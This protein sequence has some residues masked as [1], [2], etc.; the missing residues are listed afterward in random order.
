MWTERWFLSC[1]AK[2]IGTLYL[3]FAL[4]SGLIGTAYSVLIRLELS[5]P[6]VQFIADNQ[7]Y[8][9]IITSHAILMIFFM[10]MP[11][12]IGGFGN[13]LLPLLVGGPDMANKS[14]NFKSHILSKYYSTNKNIN[15]KHK[16]QILGHYLAG[17]IEGDGY[18]SLTKRNQ[19]EIGITFNSKDR[20]SAEK[21]LSY[22][23]QGSLLKRKGNCV[24]LKF[25]AVKTIKRI[26]LLINGKFRTPKIDK[27]HMLIDWLNKKHSMNLDKLPLD[28]SPLY[29]NSW[30]AGFIDADGHFY[31]RN[32]VN[33]TIICKFSLEQRMIYPKTKE[34][35]ESILGQICLFLNV[36]LFTRAR[37]DKDNS[38]YYVIRVENQ[39]ST[40]ILIDYLDS[41]SLLS[42]KYLDYLN[43]KRAFN[44]IINKTHKTDEGKKIITSLKNNMNDKR[45]F[46]N[47]D[48]FKFI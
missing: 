16:D 38:S 5:G 6:G 21:L 14:L 28:N 44:E 15:N 35:F 3:I 31:I 12:L 47:W 11:A 29:N 42:S 41:N 1:N 19:I 34:S 20:P 32:S 45:T 33:Q 30:L 8:N 18:I 7:L 23:G 24:V 17:L 48:H 13:F 4:F 46:F 25:G 43:W 26:A 10:V 27:L 36:K 37:P 2:D 40:K 22:L 9:S 39:N